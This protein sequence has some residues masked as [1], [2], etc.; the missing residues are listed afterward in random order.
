MTGAP[1]HNISCLACRS[2]EVRRLETVTV[3][4]IEDAWARASGSPSVNDVQRSNIRGDIDRAQVEIWGCDRC[5]LEFA[6]P[7]H[8]WMSG[9][10]PRE[11]HGLGYD[12]HAALV[13]LARMPRSSVLDIGCGDGQFLERVASLGHEGVGIDFSQEDV[14]AARQRGVEARCADIT[15]LQSACGRMKVDVITM[16]Q[17]IEH[18]RSP[19][20]V[21]HQLGMVA[22][23]EAVLMIGCPSDL[24]YTRA[25]AHPQKILRSD[26]WDYP[27][28]H[29]SRW[30]AEALKAFL[31]ARGWEPEVIRY[32]P[33]PIIGAA[34]HMTALRSLAS[35]YREARWHRRMATAIW[36]MRLSASRLSG[37]STGI[38]LF[39]KAC[40]RR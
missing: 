20:A 38:R 8:A 6:E 7:M 10:Y 3:N 36:M 19:D 15:D 5:G 29:L 39:T 26:F 37:R 22:R 14:A 16:F 17:V 1:A 24:R 33:L 35:E 34:A 32:E 12:H 30:S 25:Y 9:R 13:E 4:A 27:P 28:H 11:D 2:A 40:R 23:T 31:L 21:F 18:L